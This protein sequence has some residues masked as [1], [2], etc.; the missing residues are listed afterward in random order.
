MRAVLKRGPQQDRHPIERRAA[1]R[2]LLKQTRDLD[3]LATFAGRRQD[4]HVFFRRAGRR[5]GRKEPGLKAREGRRVFAHVVD[6]RG[7]GRDR[8]RAFVAE[9]YRDQR[10]R[11]AIEQRL[12]ELSF[13]LASDGHVEKHDGLADQIAPAAAKRHFEGGTKDA[14]P[15]GDVH[16]RELVLESGQH[17]RRVGI[18]ELVRDDGPHA[19]L[20]E[21]AR[22][23]ARKARS[24]GDDR[25]APEPPLPEAVHD[26]GAN[27][28]EGQGTAGRHAARAER[29]RGE[30]A[31]EPRQCEAVPAKR[32]A[33]LC[34]RHAR[35]LGGRIARRTH[36]DDLGTA[37]VSEQELDA[38]PHA[39]ESGGRP[40]YEL[41]CPVRAGHGPRLTFLHTGDR[42]RLTSAAHASP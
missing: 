25:E 17:A 19:K 2:L 34:R 42:T 36:D 1:L 30:G 4:D 14:R 29:L 37:P 5:G 13:E 39:R 28:L 41:I 8:G 3:A 22:E 16:P 33:G 15:V 26:S 6:E 9:R 21:R 12:D 31:R 32:A 40:K 35:E 7:A 38:P 11:G 10:R 23:G 24:I 27:R 18:G 20:V